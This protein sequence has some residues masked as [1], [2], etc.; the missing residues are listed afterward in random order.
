MDIF[1][2]KR[3]YH[4]VESFDEAAKLWDFEFIQLDRGG[5]FADFIQFGDQ[6]MIIGTCHW[7]RQLHQKGTSPRNYYTFALHGPKSVPHVWRYLPCPLNSIIIFPE[8]NE[9][10]SVSPPGYQTITVSIEEN[11]FQQLAENLGYPELKSFVKKGEVL[12]CAPQEIRKIQYFLLSLC[13]TA[14]EPNFFSVKNILSEQIKWRTA[15]F[16]LQALFS[17]CEH[18]VTKTS[19]KRSKVITR[20][21]DHLEDDLAS[22]VTIPDLCRVAEVSERT[23]RNVFNSTFSIGPKKYQQYLKLNIV[24]KELSRFDSEYAFISD[25]ANSNGFWHMGQFAADYYDFFNE[26]PRDTKKH[27][28]VVAQNLTSIKNS[29][30]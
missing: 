10:S 27:Q 20:V 23:L 16:L 2:N 7:N 28:E 1:L 9:L 17:G 19:V 24:R 5:F 14:E 21:L 26:L 18:K 30:T 13:R 12:L 4:A 15:K 6:E 8:N 22:P 11:F 29:V 25:V 3:L